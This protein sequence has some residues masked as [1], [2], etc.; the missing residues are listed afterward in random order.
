MNDEIRALSSQFAADPG[1]LVFLRL[2]EVLRTGGQVEAGGGV[3]G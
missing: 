2:G 3:G 1:S